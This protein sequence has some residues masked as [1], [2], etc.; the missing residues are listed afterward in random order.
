MQIHYT[1][2]E[3]SSQVLTGGIL[4]GNSI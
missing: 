2:F 3:N 4:H 1:T